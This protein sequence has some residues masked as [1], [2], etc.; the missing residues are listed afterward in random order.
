M[1][2]RRLYKYYTDRRWAEAFLS[3]KLSFRSLAYFR[4]FEDKDIRA[5]QNEGTAVY[6]PEGGLVVNNLTQG[7]TFTLPGYAFESSAAAS[8]IFVFCLSRSLRDELRAEFQAVACVEVLDIQRFCSRIKAALPP[9]AKFPG[10]LGRTRIGWRVEYY[11][12]SEG[13]SPRWALPD[14]IATAK[15]IRYVRQ[16]EFRLVFSLTDAFAFE[17]VNTRLT[18]QNMPRV[19]NPADHRSYYVEAQSLADI[20]VLLE[21]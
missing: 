16:D 18:Q 9:H 10:P 2:S 13:G 19:P 1:R 3:G 8:E 14:K 7:T 17:N 21:F 15:S 5:D 20:C 6:R 4:D 11:Q 12:E